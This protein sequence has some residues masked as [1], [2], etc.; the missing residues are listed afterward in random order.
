[1]PHLK[2][3]LQ[4]MKESMYKCTTHIQIHIGQ[5]WK[6]RHG[7]DGGGGGVEHGSPIRGEVDLFSHTSLGLSWPPSALKPPSS[8]NSREPE[9]LRRAFPTHLNISHSAR[10]PELPLFS[11][12]ACPLLSISVSTEGCWEH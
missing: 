1:V 9:S 2:Q 5:L 3:F 10:N 8:S 6:G 11:Q 7:G 12:R 4:H